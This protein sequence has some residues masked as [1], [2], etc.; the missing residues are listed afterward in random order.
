MMICVF[1]L[2]KFSP[3]V[4]ALCLHSAEDCHQPNSKGF[5]AGSW[6]V[7]GFRVSHRKNLKGH[8]IDPGTKI[9]IKKA[10]ILLITISF[11]SRS[12]A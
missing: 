6:A 11:S 7:L 12:R 8:R 2:C 1:S 9:R 5:G 3:F 10:T 4:P